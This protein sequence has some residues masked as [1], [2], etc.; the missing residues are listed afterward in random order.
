MCVAYTLIVCVRSADYTGTDITFN[1][2]RFLPDGLLVT[3]GHA[4]RTQIATWVVLMTI[5]APPELPDL[6]TKLTRFKTTIDNLRG[7]HDL[8]NETIIGW[9]I[10]I[11][12]IED[13]MHHPDSN[14]HRDRRG[15]FNAFGDLSKAMFGTATDADVQEVKNQL[16]TFGATNSRVVHYVSKL[17]TVVNHTHDQLSEN[18]RH[19]VTLH[20]YCNQLSRAIRITATA[21]NSTKQRLTILQ[22]K[23]RIEQILRG[24]EASHEYW[25]RQVRTFNRQK[26]ALELGF[27]TED[28]V[29]RQDLLHVV[30]SGR[31]AG[32]YTPDINWYYSNIRVSPISWTG[33][34]LIFRVKLPLTDNVL[35]KRYSV[36]SWP[37]PGNS[38]HYNVKIQVPSDFAIHTVTGGIFQPTFCQGEHPMICR[39]G[40][41][42]DRSRFQCPRGILT[43]E[44]SLRKQ[45]RITLTKALTTFTTVREILP[46]VIVILTRGEKVSLLCSGDPEV[47]LTLL[48]GAYA[49]RLRQDCHLKAKGW[50]ISGITRLSSTIMVD[51]TVIDVPPMPILQMIPPF[52]LNDTLM[53]PVWK[54]MGEIKN[55]ELN[56]LPAIDYDDAPV[57][58][59]HAGH[60]S[61]SSLIVL[62]IVTVIIMYILYA[63]WHRG[64]IGSPKWTSDSPSRAMKEPEG[65]FE[66]REMN[67]EGT[68]PSTPTHTGL[69]AAWQSMHPEP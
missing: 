55:F 40:A 57:W 23:L 19:I 50:S 27:L 2:P 38:T 58:G 6:Q 3:G 64:V 21:V 37:I 45:C 15:L 25:L 51:L 12:E 43:G 56:D 44:L 18:R 14:G 60:I 32:F 54:T 65:P 24:L 69:P 35:Y 7:V 36:W 66:L 17:I 1:S 4:T 28:L 31:R 10:R 8:A 62:G 47:R 52:K 49:L 41:I 20:K 67:P 5:A 26:A 34:Q 9:D 22:A 13:E 53:S 61:W 59:S 29:N 16:R 63:L 39:A 11:A 48:S 33:P 30:T 46:G 42:F 68:N